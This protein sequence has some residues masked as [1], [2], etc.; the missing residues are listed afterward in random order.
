[1]CSSDLKII[2]YAATS[3]STT[4]L[5]YCDI[6]SKLIDYIVD[7]T[8]D[9]QNK[10]SPGKHIPIISDIRFK[11]ENSDYCILFAYNHQKEIFSKEKIPGSACNCQVCAK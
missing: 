7:S 1:M 2:G 4:I 6:D 3:K 9:K 5:N 10:F 8:P 11:N